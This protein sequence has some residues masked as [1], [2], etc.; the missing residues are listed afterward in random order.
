MLIQRRNMIY[1]NQ[2]TG[3]IQLVKRAENG[4]LIQCM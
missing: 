1:N 4:D 2:N 3:D